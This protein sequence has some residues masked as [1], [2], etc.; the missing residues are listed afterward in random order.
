MADSVSGVLALCSAA[1]ASTGVK[2]WVELLLPAITAPAA[3]LF[4][5]Y[6]ANRSA[7]KREEAQRKATAAQVQTQLENTAKESKRQREFDVRRGVYL[8]AAE[9]ISQGQHVVGSMLDLKTTDAELR[10]GL[11]RVLGNL[12]KTNVI[13]TLPTVRAV[14]DYAMELTDAALQLWVGRA[15]LQHYES[16][17]SRAASLMERSNAEKA[18]VNTELKQVVTGNLALERTKELDSRSKFLDGQFQKLVEDS[19]IYNAE[20]G[21]VFNEYFE[22]QIQAMRKLQ[23]LLPAALTAAR[24]ELELGVDLPAVSEIF[25][26]VAHR[27]E[28]GA[29]RVLDEMRKFYAS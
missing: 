26:T 23:A 19:N 11:K 14:S 25:E 5:V 2:H 6:L 24:S 16:S 3:A 29:R 1:A 4:G 28:A 8:D 18:L 12:S 13:A 10:E 17:L 7:A 22:I 15:K 9:A 20:K 27:G 21:R